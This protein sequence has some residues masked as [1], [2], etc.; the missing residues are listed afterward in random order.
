MAFAKV[1][2]DMEEPKTR[3]QSFISWVKV[4]PYAMIFPAIL[5]FA[6]FF[7]YPIG[8]MIYLSFHDWNFVSPVKDFVGTANFSYLLN[9]RDFRE[10]IS[11]SFIY[12]FFTVALTIGISLLLAIWLNRSGKL[13]SFMQASIFSPHIISLVS[14]S[15]L[16][17][18]IM[19]GDYGLLNWLLNLIGIDSVAWLT[20]PDYALASL[21]LVAVWKGIGFNT[22]VFIAGLQS[23]PKDLY[24]A[25]ELDHT[26]PWRRFLKITVPMLSPTLF[27]LTIIGVINSFQVFETI[28][29]MTGGGPINS[30]NTFVYY[31]YEYG[32]QFFKIGYA[33]AAGVIL[34][35]I[36]SVLTLVYFKVLSKRVH[37]R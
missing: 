37:Y 32:F 14:V 9:D 33:S 19:D 34:L 1:Q 31:I 8:Y 11:N 16:W 27:F 15:M 5:V 10:V 3:Q 30:T 22:L 6:L 17:M 35:I 4:R 25:A 2:V 36:L 23:I 20:S 26:P 18:W 29:L 21:I 13:Y 12:T 28:N 7:I 24:E